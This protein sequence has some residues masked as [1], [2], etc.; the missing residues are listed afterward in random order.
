MA[1]LRQAII[2]EFFCGTE[3]YYEETGYRSPDQD[4]NPKYFQYEVGVLALYNNNRYI[5]YSMLN[6]RKYN[7]IRHFYRSILRTFLVG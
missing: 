7:N 3:E 6:I 5:N 1:Y 2:P 4:L